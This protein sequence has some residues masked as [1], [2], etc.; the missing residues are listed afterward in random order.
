MHSY[1][2]PFGWWL[3]SWEFWAIGLVGM[4]VLSMGLQSPSAPSVL[5][6]ILPLGIQGSV[7][8]LAVSICICLSKMLAEPLTGQIYLAPVCKYFCISNNVGVWCQWMGWI[9]TWGN[10]WMAFPSVSPS[11]FFFFFFLYSYTFFR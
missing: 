6:L 5:A 2:I 3:I 11:S 8:W 1:I 10:L 9:T 4:V 7:L